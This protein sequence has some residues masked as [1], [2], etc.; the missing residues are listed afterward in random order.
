MADLP[1]PEQLRR[2]V[3]DIREV[4]TLPHVM[5][6]ILEV[7]GDPNASARSLSQEIA[8]DASLT[9]KI[10][11]I[12]NSAY[13]GFY[14]EIVLLNDAVVVLGFEEIKRICLAISVLGMLGGDSPQDEERLHFWRHCF[15]TAA[16]AELI[17][18]ELHR[19][20][21]GA[22]TAGLLHD[23]G[24]AVLDQK[25]PEL[26]DAV[27]RCQT[28]AGCAAAQAEE[29]LLGVTHAEVGF[30]LAE[31]WN[32]PPLLA[33]A[34]RFHHQPGAATDG[35]PMAA[36]VHIADVLAHRRS[37]EELDGKPQREV[38]PV[39][40]QTLGIGYTELEE[41]QQAA[42]KKIEAGESLVS[43]LVTP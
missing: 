42:I 2:Q 9:A 30:W 28:E 10:L 19:G 11:K 37:V 33:E 21:Q 17:A 13:Y 16:L 35:A 1:T 34:I 8:A 25:F 40:L 39:A 38:D 32:L 43:E 20:S 7:I 15:D 12:V 24:R 6:R 31:R 41:L 22:F 3:E 23:I 18:R 5:L 36:V 14:R 4:A 26:Y 27:R 29:A